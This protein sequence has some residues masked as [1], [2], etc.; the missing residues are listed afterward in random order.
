MNLRYAFPIAVALPLLA[1]AQWASFTGGGQITSIR[2]M[3]QDVTG[4]YA[5]TYPTG[6]KKSTNGGTVWAPVNNGLPQSGQSY[7]VESVFNNGTSLF[8]GTQSGVY[9]SDD[10]GAS[11]SAANGT[12]TASNT[13]FANKWFVN[14]G[15]TMAIFNGDIASGGGIWRTTNGGTTWTIGHSGM[16]SNARVYNICLHS[17][18]FLYASSNVGLYISNDGGLNWQISSTM[19]YSCYA[20]A[21]NGGNLIALTT[22]GY[23]YSSNNNGSWTDATGDPASPTGGDI[24]VFDGK[25]YATVVAGGGGSTSDMLVSLNSG[26]T[27]ASVANG[28]GATD[29]IS[30]QEFFVSPSNLYIGALLD[31]YTISD[32]NVGMPEEAFEHFTIAPNAFEASFIVTGAQVVAGDRFEVLD[33]VGRLVLSTPASGTSTVIDR[34]QLPSGGYL[35]LH[36]RDGARSF[37]GRLTAL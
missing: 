19:N 26:L 37:V 36:E 3:T 17:N 32:N 6:I 7:F 1:T 2:S 5:V 12:L 34:G 20:I 8:A 15:V 24:A 27:W 10:N 29:L 31:I 30:M 14:A 23:K 9:R 13:V 11:W 35:L 33:M 22:F 21:S 4:H 25:V 28:I 18:G 16:G